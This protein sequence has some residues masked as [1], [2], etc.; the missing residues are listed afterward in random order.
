MRKS[1][2]VF[3]FAAVIFA[4]TI[5]ADD[6]RTTASNAGTVSV[7]DAPLFV[8][9]APPKSDFHFAEL[10]VFTVTF[11]SCLLLLNATRYSIFST[12]SYLEKTRVFPAAERIC[13]C[14]LASPGYVAR[15]FANS[16]K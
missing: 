11:D 3:R 10:D 12:G 15:S 2:R 1:I 6:C 5:A 9:V 14:P 8:K 16:P 4:G 13:I 7:T